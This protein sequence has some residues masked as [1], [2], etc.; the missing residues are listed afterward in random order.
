MK[1]QAS[2]GAVVEPNSKSGKPSPRRYTFLKIHFNI[3][4]QLFPSL[5]L[6]SYLPIRFQINV[7]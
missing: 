1:S 7:L 3:F 4:T 2:E 6:V 5:Q